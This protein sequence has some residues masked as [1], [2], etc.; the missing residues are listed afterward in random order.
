MKVK[1]FESYFTK[2]SELVH[3][4]KDELIKLDQ[5]FGDGDLGI[6]MDAG[7]SEIV[8]YSQEC[9]VEDLGKYF[10]GLSKAFN[11]AA[12]SSL[13]TIISFFFMGMAK[14]LKGK[15]D[16][17]LQD[18]KI[19]FAKGI[20]MIENKAGSKVGEKTILD[21]LVPA[22]E[23]FNQCDDKTRC[24][25]EAYL[26]AKSGMLSTKEQVAVHGRAAYHKEKT[27]GHIDGGA[28]LAYLV[29]K[30]VTND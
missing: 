1:D 21:T 5:A 30:A 17:S 29:F 20:E 23:A 9:Q 18:L 14:S 11:E 10:L 12:P 16:A 22:I 25:N 8:K 27:L 19:A 6:T 28:Y 26:A 7:F 13:G 15:Y 4:E 24:L 3:S 2:I